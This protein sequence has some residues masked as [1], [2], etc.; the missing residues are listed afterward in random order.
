MKRERVSLSIVRISILLALI[1]FSTALQLHTAAFSEENSESRALKE[2]IDRSM[3]SHE[4]KK[5]LIDIKEYLKL[6]PKDYWAYQVK[7]RCLYELDKYD[8]A[9]SSAEKA[10]ALNKNDFVSLT[11]LG[12]VYLK[13]GN[14]DKAIDSFNNAISINSDYT[15]AHVGAGRAYLQKK[16][17]DKARKEFRAAKDA[18]VHVES[19]LWQAIAESYEAAGLLNDAIATYREFLQNEPEHAQMNY[20]L[21][22][23][24]EKK[25]DG[26]S[27]GAYQKAVEYGYKVTI[28]HET[29]GDSLAKKKDYAGAVKEYERAV[30]LGSTSPMIYYRLGLLLFR[31]G[32]EEKAVPCLEKATEKKPDLI[33][34]HLALSSIYLGA[35]KYKECI[36]HC[37]VI[38]RYEPKNDTA[39]YNIA[40][41]S[42]MTG[43]KKEA[44]SALKKAVELLP[45]NKKLAKD[46][47]SFEALKNMPE[48]KTIT[49]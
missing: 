21:G 30:A 6:S 44:L 20:L 35:K 10:V 42:A 7:G 28:Y 15:E 19:S 18:S 48:F 25:G 13:K 37:R 29:L 4:Y 14:A 43:N 12:A 39:W 46:E 40:C 33:N 2:N 38:I 3:A 11:L 36:A 22:K 26:R 16:L 8:S 47:K 31:N 1:A 32:K 17:P 27:L 24:Y 5:A 9:F 23:V 41:A 34:A 49:E 45:S